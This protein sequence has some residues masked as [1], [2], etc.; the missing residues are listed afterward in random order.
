MNEVLLEVCDLHKSFTVSRGPLSGPPQR[1]RAVAGVS[2]SLAPG[3]TLGLVGES[4][5]GKSTTGRLITRLIEPDS[6]VIR[7]GGTDLTRLNQ[8][9]LRPYRR[10]MQMI[11]QDP[12]SSLNPRMKVFDILAEPLLL[13]GLATGKELAV[14]VGELAHRVGLGPEHLDRYPHEFSGGQRQRIG[15]ARAIA[16]RP[17]LIVADEPVSALDLSIQ[18][19]VINLLRDIQQQDGL[20]YLFIAHDLAVVEHISDR[21]AVMYLGRIVELGPARELYRHPLHPYTEALLNAVPIPD[22]KRRQK[23]QILAGEVPS[24]ITPPAGCPFHPRCPYAGEICRVENPPLVEKDTGHHTACHYSE[25]VG[26]YRRPAAPAG[27]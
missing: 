9:K 4:G 26:R 24:P 18:A 20:S 21:V 22:P 1:L 16:V 10:R 17:E 5:C 11:F 14:E 13:H 8:R 12:F 3:E 6:G 7:F 27:S 25:Q 2:F 19:Q 15:I 23:R